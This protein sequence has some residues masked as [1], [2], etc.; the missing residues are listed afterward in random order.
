MRI[1]RSDE[2]A[3]G[4]ALKDGEE[5]SKEAARA[6][7]PRSGSQ[8][9]LVLQAF[10]NSTLGLTDSEMEEVINL[11]YNSFGPRRRELVSAGWVEKTEYVRKS[12]WGVNQVVWQIT[13]EGE[14]QWRANE[15]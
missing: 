2:N 8:R 10:H 5:T 4:L 7:F 13:P 14:K 11:D 15:S 9:W 3:I 6:V 12:K 1:T